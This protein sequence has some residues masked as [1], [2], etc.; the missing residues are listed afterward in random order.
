MVKRILVLDDDIAVL[1]AIEIAL[2]Y[3]GYEVFTLGHTYNI[4]KTLD[5]YR[6]ELLL[7]D[8]VLGG[9]TG[10]ELCRR[11]KDNSDTMH[12][13]VIIVSAYPQS[14]RDLNNCGCDYFIQKPF[15]LEELYAGINKASKMD[16]EKS[17]K[18][19]PNQS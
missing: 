18:L 13:P 19:N 3:E 10:G 2:K 8:F 1:E 6:P 7:I 9:V 11:L 16:P 5:D 17:I 4:F 15:S 12:I 14:S